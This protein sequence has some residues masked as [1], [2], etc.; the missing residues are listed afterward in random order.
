MG[1]GE[2]EGESRGAFLSLPHHQADYIKAMD[3]LL[4]LSMP[5]PPNMLLYSANLPL[6]SPQSWL[7]QC[8]YAQPPAP[9]AELTI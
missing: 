4:L 5:P 6:L 7:H 2:A 1:R 9:L 8:S 3:L